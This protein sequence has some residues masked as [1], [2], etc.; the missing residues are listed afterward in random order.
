MSPVLQT[1]QRYERYDQRTNCSTGWISILCPFHEEQTPSCRINME[2][3]RYFCFGCEAKGEFYELL[4]KIAHC[5]QLEAFLLSLHGFQKN[6]GKSAENTGISESQ[7]QAIAASFQHYEEA[8]ERDWNR[9]E[10]THYLFE[11]GFSPDILNQEGVRQVPGS[12]HPL[13]FPLYEQRRFVGTVA[14]A[15]RAEVT[16]KYRNSPGF[17]RKTSLIGDLKV[18]RVLVVEGI[19]DRM[20]LLSFGATNVVCL[21]GKSCSEVQYRKL[22]AYAKEV[23]LLLDPDEAGRQ[24]AEKIAKHLLADAVPMFSFPYPMSSGDPAELQREDFEF[25]MKQLQGEKTTCY[26]YQRI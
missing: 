23:V 25:G 19:L 10:K 18:G 22:R 24:G 20:R 3:G 13:L 8:G 11:R 7:Q 6:T 9:V 12:A 26:N 2:T 5:T 14:R 21:L 16:P 1:L 15:E 4:A 17:S